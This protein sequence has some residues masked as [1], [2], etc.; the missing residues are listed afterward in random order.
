MDGSTNAQ[1]SVPVTNSIVYQQTSTVTLVQGINVPFSWTC[2]ATGHYIVTGYMETH[3][4]PA[5][6]YVMGLG[7][8]NQN[9]DWT[10][11]SPVAI[12]GDVR[13]NATRLYGLTAGQTVYLNIFYT[14]GDSAP[15]TTVQLSI[16]RLS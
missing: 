14:A 16:A 7:I 2:N 11:S 3:S 8:N 5:S 9:G 6:N 15:N 10:Q 4:A 12:A 13:M 1:P